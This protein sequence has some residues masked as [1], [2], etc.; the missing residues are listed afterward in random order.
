M[1]KKVLAAL[2]DSRFYRFY[3]LLVLFAYCAVFYYLGELVDFFGWGVLRLPFFYTVHDIHRL[4]FLV[5][6]IYAAHVFRVRGAFMV[7]AATLL[8]ILPRALFISPFPDPLLRMGLFILGAGTIGVLTAVARNETERRRRLEEVVTRERDRLLGILER[9]EEGVIII[10]PDY[11]IRYMNSSMRREF[12]EGVGTLC[13]D[14][15][16]HFEEPCPQICKLPG[17]VQG[18]VARW[19]YTFPDGRTFEVIA[20]PYRDSDGVACQLGVYRNI[21]QRKKLET[22]LQE[23]NR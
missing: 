20:S 10:G 18:S 7:T 14:Y 15:L 21:T 11:R 12:G 1:G 2:R 16:H 5:P 4:F 6:I 13:Y 19:E 17:I 3:V 22:E 23:L 8:V 9:M